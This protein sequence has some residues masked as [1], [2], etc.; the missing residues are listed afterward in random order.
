MTLIQFVSN[1]IHHN[2][3]V[4][5]VY[6]IKGGYEVVSLTWNDVCMGHEIVNGKGIYADFLD[7]NVINVCSIFVRGNFVEAINIVIESAVMPIND[8]A[9]V[10]KTYQYRREVTAGGTQMVKY[11]VIKNNDTYIL[12]DKV[13]GMLDTS[14][15]M[16]EV[17][18]N[19]NSNNRN[20]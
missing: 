7:V 9:R 2:S 1:F 20:Q 10:G 17:F 19:P 4:R 11:N 5:L 13:G 3:M 8:T 16:N 18:Y 12:G 15:N 14:V 6:K